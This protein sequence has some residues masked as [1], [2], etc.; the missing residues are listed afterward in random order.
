MCFNFTLV[1]FLIF[2]IMTANP[3]GCIC[4]GCAVNA[5]PSCSN[6]CSGRVVQKCV[7]F[8]LNGGLKVASF[9]VYQGSRF[10]QNFMLA[11]ISIYGWDITIYG[12]IWIRQYGSVLYMWASMKFLPRD[13]AL[14]YTCSIYCK[15][16]TCSLQDKCQ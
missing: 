8:N 7:K 10:I 1:E 13:S 11:H 2:V 3:F 14:I 9:I 4:F 16:V 12:Y 5:G 15:L 6:F